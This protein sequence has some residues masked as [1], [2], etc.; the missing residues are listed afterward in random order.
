MKRQSKRP[1]K[2]LDQDNSG[3]TFDGSFEQAFSLVDAA[4]TSAMIS[5]TSP[6]ALLAALSY[7]FLQVA[8]ERRGTPQ[9]AQEEWI[10][11]ADLVWEPVFINIL[12]F[13]E[14]F[15]GEYNYDEAFDE[16]SFLQTECNVR[17]MRLSEIEE[18]RH[19]KVAFNILAWTLE[20][21]ARQRTEARYVELGLLIEWFKVSATINECALERYA[22]VRYHA[23]LVYNNYDAV[24]AAID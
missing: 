13:V 9:T 8:A 12:D 22:I 10:S 2:V 11:D 3:D 4:F 23:A 17:P 21:L 18:R 1:H 24:L 20:S 15:E 6:E 19:G 14:T 5:G 7:G 16:I